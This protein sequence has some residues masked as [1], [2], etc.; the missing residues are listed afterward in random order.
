MSS[1]RVVVDG[2]NIANE[3]RSMP[4]LQQLDEAVRAFLG[5]NADAKITV[6]VDATFEHRIDPSEKKLYDEANDAGE[7]IRPPAGTI[8][9]GDKFLLEIA[10]RA[11]ATVLS[12]DSFQEFHGEYE[13]LFD[14]GRLIGGKPVPGIG[15]I[16]TARTPVRGPKSRRAVR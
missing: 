7:L 2:S 3:G 16:F 12:N 1:H 8:G 13:W 9:G 11:N 4:S 15:W 10:D 5:E 6:V 14:E